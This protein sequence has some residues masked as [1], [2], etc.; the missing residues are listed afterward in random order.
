MLVQGLDV[1]LSFVGQEEGGKSAGEWVD[2]LQNKY[3]GGKGREGVCFS[4]LVGADVRTFLLSFEMDAQLFCEA[5][6]NSCVAAGAGEGGSGQESWSAE[7]ACNPDADRRKCPH[8][9]LYTEE[10]PRNSV[11]RTFSLSAS[12]LYPPTAEAM[13]AGLPDVRRC[14]VPGD[15]PCADAARGEGNRTRKDSPKVQ[16][17]IPSFHWNIQAGLRNTCLDTLVVVRV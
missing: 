16:H 3:S 1:N 4:S 10:M 15:A 7:N 8:A 11:Q 9:F 14:G 12:M 6:R 5:A 13:P 2:T 17:S